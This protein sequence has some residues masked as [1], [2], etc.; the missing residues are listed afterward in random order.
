MA[1]RLRSSRMT[2]DDVSQPTRL[3]PMD[4]HRRLQ[5]GLAEAV[6]S[7]AGIRHEGLNRIYFGFFYRGPIPHASCQVYLGSIPSHAGWTSPSRS[8]RRV[9]Q[10]ER[11]FATRLRRSPIGLRTAASRQKPAICTAQATSIY[12]P[13]RNRSADL[14]PALDAVVRSSGFKR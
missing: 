4:V 11:P 6:V 8:L 13:N 7:R 1:T 5:A 12:R 3:S 10:F 9:D 2:A 14:S